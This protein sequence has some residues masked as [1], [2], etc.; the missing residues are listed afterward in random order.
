M[1]IKLKIIFL[2]FLCLF[3]YIISGKAT[4]RQKT[5]NNV[6]VFQ[7]AKL[8]DMVCTTPMFRAI[9]NRYPK[10]YLFV[11]GNAT[12]KQL[13][14]CNSDVDN[15]IVFEQRRMFSVIRDVKRENIN[16][17]CITGPDFFNLAVLYLAGVPL[18]TA[19]FIEG[20]F[21]PHE[22]ISYRFLRKL[23]TTKP[24]NMGKYAPREYL[25]LLETINICSDNT[26][27]HLSFSIK[28]DT[29]IKEL[30][31]QY[32]D[33]VLIGISPSAGNKIKEWSTVRFAE[34]A[35]Y[36]ALHYNAIIVIIG[37]PNDLKY[38]EE[39][40]STFIKDVQYID[41]TG[42]LSIDE[43]KAAISKLDLFISVDTGPLNIAVAFNVPTVNILGPVPEW[44][45]SISRF[46]R[47]VTNRVG[48]K[49]VISPMNNHDVD[50]KEARRQANAITAEMVINVVNDLCAILF[51]DSANI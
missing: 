18:I 9:K 41:T 20:G 50:F 6:M 23:V 48:V 16:F 4:K 30:F 37:G 10:C 12:N 36:I 31:S 24:H 1:K 2:L 39:M 19:P 49:H 47:I 28:A 5:L 13:L 21:S 32:K 46:N 33:K 44:S 51:R 25:R 8:G 14:E 17:A 40:K 27:K 15:Y 3:R 45:V 43:L 38:A 35:N 42:I 34:V 22:T 29:K 7:G 26:E 11:V